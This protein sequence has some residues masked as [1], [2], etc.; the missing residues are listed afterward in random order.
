MSKT[1]LVNQRQL[2]QYLADGKFYSGQWLAEQL[3]V[4]R[5]AVANYLN[6]LKQHG[7]EIFSVKGRGYKLT[8]AI[9]LLDAHKINSLQRDGS[10]QILVQHITDSTNC[11]LLQ[12]LQAGQK[13]Q[14][15]SVIVAEAQSAGR[16]RH[17]RAWYS[18][19]GTNLYFSCY[20]R[21]EQ[22]MPAAMGLSL[23]V[24][25]AICRLLQRQYQVKA[26]IKWPNDIY[27]NNR[28]LAGIL[29]ELAGQ[30]DA[31]CDVVIGIGLNI[32]MP[33]HSKQYIDQP[34]TDLRAVSLQPVERNSLVVQLQ[35]ELSSIL[36]EFAITGFAPFVTE[37]NQHDVFNNRKVSLLAKSPISGVCR[38]VDKHGGIIIDSGHATDVY[39][40]GELSL[41]SGD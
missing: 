26:Q 25:L 33:E 2:L 18:P 7:L 15:G 14:P 6:E 10:P 34:Y 17:G 37:F 35:H 8:Q 36:Q 13:L 20:W 5:T 4:S 24:G 16:G 38:G 11:Q 19:F 9:Q 27:V 30:V 31:G 28:K 41:R 23:V 39:Y 1:N 12:R 29:V 3:G 40:G 22:G 32:G 21:L